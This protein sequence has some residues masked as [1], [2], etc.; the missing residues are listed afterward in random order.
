MIGNTKSICPESPWMTLIQGFIL[1]PNLLGL[2]SLL[3][4]QID[5]ATNCPGYPSLPALPT[6]YNRVS[7]V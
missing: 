5:S 1:E 3:P 6:T 2:G 7:I 4:F